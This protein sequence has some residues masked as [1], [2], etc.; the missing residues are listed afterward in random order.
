MSKVPAVANVLAIFILT[1]GASAAWFALQEDSFQDRVA[2]YSYAQTLFAIAKALDGNADLGKTLKRSELCG[3]F[4]EW[5]DCFLEIPEQSSG[6]S[7]AYSP[8]TGK[9]KQ[10][11]DVPVEGFRVVEDF[12]VS[13]LQ[14]SHFSF[15]FLAVPLTTVSGR[16]FRGYNEQD[17]ATDARAGG[18]GGSC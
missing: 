7:T 10:Y 11:T 8:K 6:N 1:I 2:L 9:S 18:V 16:E 15:G 13:D 4:E 14:T 17:A 12:A 3:Y 5:E